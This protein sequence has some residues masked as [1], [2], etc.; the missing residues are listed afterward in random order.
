MLFEDYQ[1]LTGA[2]DNLQSKQAPLFLT[3]WIFLRFSGD[4]LPVRRPLP[5]LSI[6]F[7]VVELR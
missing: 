6:R 7:D 3:S 2:F 5:R 4:S 1:K